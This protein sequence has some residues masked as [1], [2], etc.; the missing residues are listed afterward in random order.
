MRAKGHNEEGGKFGSE[1]G[2]PCGEGVGG[3]ARGRGDDHPIPAEIPKLLLAGPH[4][5]LHKPRLRSA[6]KG[7]LVEGGSGKARPLSQKP[8]APIPNPPALEDLVEGVLQFLRST[9]TQKP[10]CAQ[11][12]GEDGD[13]LGVEGA[14]RAEEGAIPADGDHEIRRALGSGDFPDDLRDHPLPA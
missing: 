4:P 5:E 3:A 13:F 9:G 2:A 14:G 6:H 11:K 12:D 10:H 8:H 1:D 7:E